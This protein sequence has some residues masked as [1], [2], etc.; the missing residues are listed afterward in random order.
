M[1]T[2][3]LEYTGAYP[4]HV[5]VQPEKPQQLYIDQGQTLYGD[6]SVVE[7]FKAIDADYEA[8]REA[9]IAAMFDSISRLAIEGTY[10][11][12]AHF[13][14][15]H[16][17]DERDDH[18]NELMI[19]TSPLND[20]KPTSKVGTM[21]QYLQAAKPSFMQVAKAKPNSWNPVTKLAIGHDLAAA[22]GRPMAM[23]Q[24]LSPVPPR[25]MKFK[26]RLKL[27]QGD[28]TAYG[29]LAATTIDHVNKQREA[30]GN[31]EKI[32]KVHFFGAGIGQRAIGAARYIHENYE[33]VEVASVHAMNLSLHRGP[34][35]LVDHVLQREVDQPSRE[36][37]PMT[38]RKIAEPLMR[39]EIDRRGDTLHVIG[40]QLNAARHVAATLWPLFRAYK[41]TVEDIGV[42]LDA[43]V[44]VRI[45]NSR[46]VS[47]AA[48]TRRLLEEHDGR[49]EYTDIVA[50]PGKKVGMMANEHAALV[51]VLM[52]QGVRDADSRRLS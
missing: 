30:A 18:S 52:N 11:D 51:A 3:E 10:S 29:K 13:D 17:T 5:Q 25:A 28:Y 44:P 38:F 41:P 46:N 47:M 7:A 14:I 36:I 9:K 23:A 16:V 22:S 43:E 48:N 24:I 20:G 19:L 33:G 1:S 4:D 50:S 45:S 34:T 31:K 2:L 27:I 40:R 6:T 32:T 8:N 21:M 49:F 26:D 35:G 42:L 37:P 12:S 39:R 15:A